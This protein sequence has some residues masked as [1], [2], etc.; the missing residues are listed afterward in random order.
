MEAAHIAN[1]PHV[2]VD[3]SVDYSASIIQDSK[4]DEIDSG[5]SKQRIYAE[6]SFELDGY[7]YVEDSDLDDG[8]YSN[9]LNSIINKYS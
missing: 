8:L 7:S 5:L 9:T 6:D 2:Y 3:D 1:S 4:V